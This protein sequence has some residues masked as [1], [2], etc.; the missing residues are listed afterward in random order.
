LGGKKMVVIIHLVSVPGGI[1]VLELWGYIR[2]PFWG[3]YKI[4]LTAKKWQKHANV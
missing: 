4:S 2:T 1:L 3:G